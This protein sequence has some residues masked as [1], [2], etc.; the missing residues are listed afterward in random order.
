MFGRK[1]QLFTTA[2]L[3]D[4]LQM[5]GRD[6]KVPKGRVGEIIFSS[7]PGTEAADLFEQAAEEFCIDGWM[8]RIWLDEATGTTH[9]WLQGELAALLVDQLSMVGVIEHD[10]DYEDCLR[11]FGTLAPATPR[12]PTLSDIV[13]SGTAPVHLTDLPTDMQ[14]EMDSLVRPTTPV[15]RRPRKP[16]PQHR[17]FFEDRFAFVP[18]AYSM[19]YHPGVSHYGASGGRVYMASGPTHYY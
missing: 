2:T 13:R 11:Q 17:D 7:G 3:V 6:F 10:A 18:S 16:K 15:S 5:H 14:A 12:R 19:S 4:G 1:R 9:W 8:K